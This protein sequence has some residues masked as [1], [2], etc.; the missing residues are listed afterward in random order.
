MMS[1][2]KTITIA[3]MCA[4]AS[5][6]MLTGCKD[7]ATQGQAAA[8]RQMPPTEIMYVTAKT[9]DQML[10]T[11]LSGRTSAFYEAEVR[12][13]VNGILQ[14]KLLRTVLKLRLETNSTKLT[15]PPIRLRSSPPK[16]LLLRLRPRSLRPLRTLSVQPNF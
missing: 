12:P 5:T 15:Q 16:P 9:G 1:T 8:Q 13:Q 4:L 3:L 7:D 10:E 14:K 6:A 11:V 2:R